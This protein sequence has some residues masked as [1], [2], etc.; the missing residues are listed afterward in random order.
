MGARA[1]SGLKM[2]H[3][4]AKKGKFSPKNRFLRYLMDIKLTASVFLKWKMAPPIEKTMIF[5]KN[6]HFG[7]KKPVFFNFW[8]I[9]DDW[10][11]PFYI[12]GI[13]ASSRIEKWGEGSGV[14]RFS[15]KKIFRVFGPISA[16]TMVC[17]GWSLI[18]AKI[19]EI[20]SRTP[21][22]PK[23]YVK[24]ISDAVRVQNCA[25]SGQVSILI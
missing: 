6:R 20:F 25:Q 23:K 13:S 22:Y 9:A 10:R 15:G 18:W 24:S 7:Q 4:M 11:G 12:F 8:G 17:Q 21:T 19:I 14:R 5:S 16:K 3:F 2:V 1:S